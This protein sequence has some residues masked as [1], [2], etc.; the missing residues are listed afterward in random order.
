MKIKAFQEYMR[1]HSIGYAILY[2]YNNPRLRAN[3]FYF[4]QSEEEGAII[5]PREGE[6]KK[7]STPLESTNGKIVWRKG[8]FFDFIKGQAG[9]TKRI[10]L[11]KEN[12]TLNAVRA[13]RKSFPKTELVNV[14]QE[15]L[16]LR[17]TKT[18]EEI[19]LIKKACKASE[20]IIEE[21]IQEFRSFKTETEAKK[22]LLTR[23]IEEDSETAFEPVV[24]TG[25][26]ASIPHHKPDNTK[27]GKGFAIIDFGVK[28]KGY[29]ADLTRTIFVGSPNSR[30][31]KLFELV[32]KTQEDAI[33]LIRPAL[34]AGKMQETGK[35]MLGKKLIHAIGHGVGVD[36]HEGPAITENNSE[37]L[38]KGMILCV[39]PGYYIR[40]Q[41]GIRIEDMVLVTDNGYKRISRQSELF[42]V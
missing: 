22:F 37:R 1:A 16:K 27:I 13:I 26:N 41:L 25:K 35:K 39:E 30:E 28:H 10:G 18:E 11:D 19:E 8:R 3:F 20:K 24:A 34:L 7:I 23:A 12:L 36:V 38:Q 9:R 32:Q 14:T 21:C 6:P 31:K 2:N 4:S 40:N 15:C 42:I 29:C 33:R 5:I 17:K